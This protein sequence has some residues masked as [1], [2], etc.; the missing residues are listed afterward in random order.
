[1]VRMVLLLVI[2]LG[3]A[4]P[5][6]ADEPG[7][8]T[9][10]DEATAIARWYGE[11]DAGDRRFRFVIEQ[12]TPATDDGAPADAAARWQ[13]RS[14]DEGDRSF[15]LEGYT[16]DEGRLAFE[17]PAADASY[18]GTRGESGT[19]EGSWKQRGQLLP[20]M[21]RP[22]AG[23]AVP[24]PA[25]ETWQGTLN[26]IVQKLQLRFRI[27][28]D[29]AGLRQVWMDSTTQ[30]AGGFRGD[31]SIS[32]ATWTIDVP[33]VR[34][35]FQGTLSDD[36]QTL[37]GN[38]SQS[39][40]S[41]PLELRRFDDEPVVEAPVKPRPQTPRGPF[42]YETEEITFR[43]AAADATLAG[44]L[45]RPP[46][47][48]P[49]PA[50]ILLSGSGPQDRDETLFDHKPFAVLADFLTRRGIA[51]LRF[52][53]R[54]VGQSTGSS[55]DATSEDFHF[56][57]AAAFRFLVEQPR[58]DPQRVGFIGHSEG[59]MVATMAA[60]T[61]PRVACVVML[62]GAGVDGRQVLMSQGRRVLEAEGVSDAAQL[63][64]QRRTQE[65]LMDTVEQA[66]PGVSQENLA[67]E[68]AKRLSEQLG[69]D[70]Q[71]A[72][73][74]DALAAAGVAQLSSPWFRFFL[75]FDPTKPL[76]ELDCPVL[77]LVGSRDVQVDPAVN[78]PPLREAVASLGH[79]GSAV[80]ELP[81]LNHLFQTCTTG[82]ISEYDA[83]EETMAPAVLERVAR[84][85]EER[86][87]MAS[88]P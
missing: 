44:T 22:V 62:A 4:L 77:V 33:A 45:T 46:G 7:D 48:G 30:Q 63:E 65:I 85:L 9:P 64:R 57:A 8:G 39:G 1:M 70:G 16:Q 52:D 40:I 41:L 28:R 51:V 73:D 19:V 72:E 26:A 50:V 49:F 54:G 29:A 3:Y 61:N 18:A 79:D 78:L 43:N 32:D 13:L 21:F 67:R 75:T 20:L 37:E 34:G 5:A 86:F 17:L 56:D 88:L 68:A 6:T 59:A 55:D 35:R 76:R 31:L 23:A 74:L 24:P 60:S 14:V 66:P 42:P 81:G 83:I 69:D 27:T 87:G 80:E 11:M 10:S 38:W 15:P 82:A 58:I 84:W 53:D 47:D 12:L 36:G 71:Q 2:T 25:E